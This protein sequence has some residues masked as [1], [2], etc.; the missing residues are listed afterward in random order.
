MID[1]DDDLAPRL[2]RPADAPQA[3]DGED[4]S[5]ADMARLI[6][7]ASPAYL[8]RCSV[9][10]GEVGPV[11]YVSSNI[12]RFGFSREELLSG[13]RS[14]WD[15]IHPEDR[16]RARAALR[17][18][19][20]AGRDA[21]ALDYRQ[22][23]ADGRVCHVTNHI[24]L[25]RD[26]AGR[27]VAVQALVLDVT[28]SVLARR[29]LEM[30]LDSAPI[31]I[32][33]VR[34]DTDGDRRLEY[35]NPAAERLFG[36]DAT[37][38]SCKNSLCNKETCPV[39]ADESGLVRERECLV[40]TLQGER[41]MYKTARRLPGSL[42]I[43]EAMIDV[44]ELMRTRQRLTRA[45]EAAEAA[46]HAKSQFLATMSH[47]IRTPMNGIMGMIELAAATELTPEQ[48]D[49]LDLAHQSAVHLLE[50]INDILDF[51]RIEAGRMEL[52]RSRFSLRQ[53]LGVC[54]RLFD[55]RARRGGTRLS[56]DIA[57]D[58]PDDLVGDPGRLAQIVANLVSNGLKF[59]KNGFVRVA[60][61]LNPDASRKPGMLSL[62]FNVS[63]DGIGIPPDQQ[64]RI[65][66]YFTQ[67]DASLN[68]GAGGTGLGLS[69]SKNLVTLMGGHI[70][71]TSDP[72]RGSTFFFTA[73]FGLP[74]AQPETAAAPPAPAGPAGPVIPL[75]LLLVEDNT[76]NQ[77]VAKRL[78]ERRGHMVTAVDS[79]HQ[80]LA[81]L[82]ETPF[83]CVLMDVEMPE[84]SGPETLALLR[85]PARF[86]PAAAT[87]AVALTA[88]AVKG[89]RERMLQAGFDD[90]VAKPI[91]M[92]ELDAALA[93]VAAKRGLKGEEKMPPAA[94]G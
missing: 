94:G 31:P 89:Y 67:L 35:Q 44:T 42:S 20:D 62:R 72:G 48:R 70:G 80:A 28:E 40:N 91:D 85:D 9:K 15:L 66:D 19:A 88:H 26:D 78:L 11:S 6:L 37:G 93:R 7:E 3:L 45:M 36:K 25:R 21:F 47:E 16:D 14:P 39:L 68:R 27:V 33:K 1:P 2:R 82:A 79:G 56:L 24:Q 69:I 12:D 8:I 92:H 51:S 23:T 49:Y 5:D 58:V 50:I 54:L 32:V 17:E 57:S 18:A 76:I 46:N 34:V 64:A 86:G 43:I 71:V 74:K 83:D 4:V 75:R 65:F 52:A 73:V 84:L 30:V 63:D 29:D 55:A 59:T 61:S 87:P 13:R 38:L 81:V 22:R 90:Y 53:A 60:V 77:I 10:D 41:V